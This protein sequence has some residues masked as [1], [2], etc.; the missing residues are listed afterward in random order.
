MDERATRAA[1]ACVQIMHHCDPCEVPSAAELAEVIAAEYAPLTN[2]LAAY[3]DFAKDLRTAGDDL[4]GAADKSVALL[5]HVPGDDIRPLFLALTFA[6][7][8]YESLQLD[9][10]MAALAAENPAVVLE[11]PGVTAEIKLAA[12]KLSDLEW[13]RNRVSKLW[14]EQKSG[15]MTSQQF[16]AQVQAAI[17][18]SRTTPPGMLKGAPTDA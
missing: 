1:G 2:L 8:R 13:L 14:A 12:A 17:M 15:R 3:A 18:R 9:E 4:L 7:E 16:S 10:R 6:I 11:L 5:R